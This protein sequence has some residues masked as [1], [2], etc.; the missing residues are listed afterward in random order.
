M[1]HISDYNVILNHNEIFYLVIITI[2]FIATGSMTGKEGEFDHTVVCMHR[3]KGH[4]ISFVMSIILFQKYKISIVVNA[5]SSNKIIGTLVNV[6]S[7]NLWQIT[8]LIFSFFVS[9][10]TALLLRAYEIMTAT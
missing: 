10:N 4:F 6:N 1:F 3:S 2:H 8:K 9:G 5:I 7:D